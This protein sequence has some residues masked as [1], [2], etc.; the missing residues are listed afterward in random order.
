MFRRER[1]LLVSVFSA[2]LFLLYGEQWMTML[3]NPDMVRRHLAL[4]IRGDL[5]CIDWRSPT[6][7]NSRR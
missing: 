5:V 4:A 3:G 7:R 1:T 6:C 2:I